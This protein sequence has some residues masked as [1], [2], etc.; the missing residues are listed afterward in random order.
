MTRPA[1]TCSRHILQQTI[2]F[3]KITRLFT[4]KKSATFDAKVAELRAENQP[5]T[6]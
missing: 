6:I 1:R 4:T 5:F 2:N 3:S